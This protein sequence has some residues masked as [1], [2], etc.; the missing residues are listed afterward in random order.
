[1]G[2]SCALVAKDFRQLLPRPRVDAA[3]V[4][5]GGHA[6]RAVRTV[7]KGGRVLV[8][9]AEAITRDLGYA[10]AATIYV[11]RSV[12]GLRVVGLA[13]Q[14]RPAIPK[15]RR[16]GGN[17]EAHSRGPL[18]RHSKEV[19]RELACPRLLVPVQVLFRALS[20]CVAAAF[21]V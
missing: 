4:P 15:L 11:L 7:S 13:P 10:M 18:V 19:A 3:Y 21:T 9:V 2:L 8:A 20:S 16:D 6:K 14:M 1:M 5:H 12:S 17:A